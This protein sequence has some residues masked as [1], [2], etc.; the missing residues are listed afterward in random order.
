MHEQAWIV[1]FSFVTARD[2]WCLF[3]CFLSYISTYPFPYPIGVTGALN[4]YPRHVEVMLYSF[5]T[6]LQYGGWVSE[7]VQELMLLAPSS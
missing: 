1:Y 5:T 6:E 2:L 3:F 7:D 4:E